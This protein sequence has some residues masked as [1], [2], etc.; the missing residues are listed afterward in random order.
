MIM[1]YREGELL[2]LNV[3][4]ASKKEKKK[5]SANKKVNDLADAV[6]L[7]KTEINNQFDSLSRESEEQQEVN[8][9]S[10]K[11]KAGVA[12]LAVKQIKEEV[13]KLQFVFNTE[14][15]EGLEQLQK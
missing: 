15:I 4:I 13:N 12:N 11:A 6:N 7:F 8:V 10:L 5:L 2:D 14:I 9:L 1:G 3:H